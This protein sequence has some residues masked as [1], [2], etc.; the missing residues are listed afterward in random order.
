M[1]NILIKL[2]LIITTG[3][4]PLTVFAE[5]I[6]LTFRFNDPEHKE[7][8]MALDEFEEANPGVKVKLERIA[9]SSSRDQLLR[10][11][12]IGKGPDVVHSAFVWV[13]EFAQS[14]ALKPIN[15]LEQYSPFENGFDDFVATDLTYHDGKAYGVPWTAD[16]WSMVYNNNVLKEA[17]IEIK[18]RTWEEVLE[19]SRKIKKETGK[20]GFSFLGGD[21]GSFFINYYLWSNGATIVDDDGNGGFKIGV[22]EKQLIE[23][24][25]YFKTYLDEG[26]VP[27]AILSQNTSR[28]PNAIQPLLDDKQAMTI[29]P[30]AAVRSLV[31][32]YRQSYPNKQMP[33][34]TGVTPAGTT[35]ALTHLGGRT[36][37]VNSS[38]KH[39]KHAWLLLKHLISP[40]ILKKYYT[41]Q[42]PANKSGLAFVEFAEHEKGFAKQYADHTR[43]WGPYAR[44]PAPIGQIRN[45]LG[46]SFGSAISG[47]KTSKE[48]A[49][50]ILKEVSRLMK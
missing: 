30:I 44:G 47:Q 49:Q 43:S 22:S 20:I 29:M 32:G 21:G 40:Q 26:L 5:E 39:P 4:T 15:E 46:R 2:I 36:L 33:F 8:R 35:K 18:P 14:G 13:E 27:K 16:T 7:M 10:E 6:N 38:T 17:G 24:L 45:T 37:V 48:A 34:E 42:M 11:A 19:V 1:S 12:A 25:D 28:D 23:C 41:K 31:D 3:F 50:T 9:W